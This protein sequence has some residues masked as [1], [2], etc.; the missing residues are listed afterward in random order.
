MCV[1]GYEH[2]STV[3]GEYREGLSCPA[4]GDP[5]DCELPDVGAGNPT[6]LFCKSGENF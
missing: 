5:G 4:A 3:P 2:M 1:S 6:W